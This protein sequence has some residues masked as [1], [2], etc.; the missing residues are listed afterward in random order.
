MTKS[1]NPS[2]AVTEESAAALEGIGVNL[3]EEASVFKREAVE[4]IPGVCEEAEPLPGGKSSFI[5]IILNVCVRERN[6]IK[7]Q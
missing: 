4:E 7:H 1:T 6:F 5:L 3:F 2:G